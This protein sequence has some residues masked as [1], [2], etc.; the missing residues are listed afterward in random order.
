[1]NFLL[2][3]HL[4]VWAATQPRRVPKPVA[5]L[6]LNPEH[7]LTFSVASIWKIAIKRREDFQVNPR[8]LRQGLLDYGYLELPVASEHAIVAG[9]LPWIHRDPFDRMLVAQSIS[10]GITLLTV[11]P[12]LAR[13][14]APVKLF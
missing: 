3:S 14:D 4:L 11:D 6:I 10:E 13:Y 9:A 1:M 8:R 2:D 5:E 12:K 7:R